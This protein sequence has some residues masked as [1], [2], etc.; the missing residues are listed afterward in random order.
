[1]TSLPERPAAGPTGTSV[2]QVH[3][4]RRCNLRC[5]HCYSDSGPNQSES[6]PIDILKTAV[7]DAAAE[8]FTTLGVSGGEPL[9]YEPLADLLAHARSAG[10][11]TTVTS[12]GI[13]LS[14]RRLAE[15]ASYTSLLA[16]SLDGVPQSHNAMR[17]ARHAFE[18][19]A[20]RLPAVRASGIDFGF[21]FTLTQHNV[22]ELEWVLQFALEE[23]AKLLQIHPLEIAGRA[24]DM[25]PEAHPDA[26]E[27]AVGY[28]EAYRAQ[29]LA[30]KR[31]RV[32]IDLAD[33]A[34]L[35]AEPARVFADESF[36]AAADQRLASLVT[37]LIIEA[38]G[39]VVPFAYGFPPAYALGNINDDRL[40]AMSA[41]WVLHCYPSLRRVCRRA[42]QAITQSA[43]S[44][45][46][47]NWYEA[48]LAQ[49]DGR[50]NRL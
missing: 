18:F 5:V 6:L 8:G 44:T 45:P 30:G 21:I 41:R 37:P 9:L 49:A 46:V 34:L 1:M 48:V 42:F 12:N 32:H 26:R 36:E 15:I 24:A 22:H 29:A 11:I 47:A 13:L 16:I 17:G 33:A 7:T 2:L 50:I 40:T 43:A 39:L 4:T 19:M 20:K 35:G 31:L 38:S 28:I 10:M 14:A 3:P 27:M 23:G 25:L